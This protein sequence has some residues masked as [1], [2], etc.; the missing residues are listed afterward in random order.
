MPALRISMRKIK[1]VLRLRFG[2]GLSIRKTAAAVKLST[3]ATQSLVKRAEH[4]KLSWP[5]PADLDDAALER[6]FYPQRDSSQSRFEIPDWCVATG[7]LN[8]RE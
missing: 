7:N 8:V 3:G 5:L 4:L 6:C 1:E 2:S